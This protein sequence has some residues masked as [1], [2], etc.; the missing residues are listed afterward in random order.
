M[1]HSKP[2]NK[3]K[4][5][6]S[7]IDLSKY[8]AIASQ[9]ASCAED[10][11]CIVNGAGIKPLLFHLQTQLSRLSYIL[12]EPTFHF[13]DPSIHSEVMLKC[14]SM[15]LD[16]HNGNNDCDIGYLVELIKNIPKY[17]SN[18]IHVQI[19]RTLEN[20][21]HIEKK[22]FYPNKRE[23]IDQ[24][25]KHLENL[26][27]LRKQTEPILLEVERLLSANQPTLSR[28]T[29][30]HESLVQT[31]T[32]LKAADQK[33]QK[34]ASE[35][36]ARLRADI[37]TVKKAKI[38][39]LDEKSRSLATNLKKGIKPSAL[40]P[41]CGGPIGE[42]PHLDHIYPIRMGGLSVLENLVFVC[43]ECN[44][45]KGDMGVVQFVTSKSYDLATVAERLHKLGKTI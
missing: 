17:K 31:T 45:T 34:L 36:R 22:W 41:Y 18:S 42:T 8:E 28:L 40:C 24:H 16:R 23:C 1:K 3:N 44:L 7:S 10:I 39:R 27:E 21:A 35:E 30:L 38:A 13:P 25:K 6:P 43:R 14:N 4:M 11:Q 33:I 20:V 32:W 5:S 37:E 12:H 9:N 19:E 29:E 26:E 15:L 2:L